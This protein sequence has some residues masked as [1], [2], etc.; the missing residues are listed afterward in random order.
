MVEE[1]ARR[2][3]ELAPEVSRPSAEPARGRL[4]E[5]DRVRLR[6]SGADGVVRELRESRATVEVGGLRLKVPVSQVELVRGGDPAPAGGREGAPRRG[7]WSAPEVEV[8]HEADLR[9][10][11]VDEVELEL[12]RALDGA[13]VGNLAELRIIHGKG[14]GA[15]K[16]RVRELLRG[17][18]RVKELRPGG[19]GEGGA[20][21]TVAVLR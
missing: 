19:T 3:E 18:G 12:A 16:A 11:R 8:R 20:G 5:G 15:V 4:A 21:V 9:G 13:V 1:A 6:G 17:D 14:T 2:Q 10:L 7:A